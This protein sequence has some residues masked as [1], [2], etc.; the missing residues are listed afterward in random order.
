MTQ[1]DKI[2]N[3]N[4]M[5]TTNP[6]EIQ[7]IIG[8]SY[9]KLYANELDNLEEMDKFRNTH[10]LP[11][12]NQEERES[13]NRPITG[14]EI[15]SVIKNLP[16]NKSPGPDGF[17]GE[18][19]QTFKAE[20]IS[21]LFKLFQ[22]IE[23]EGK[24]PDSFYE[25]SITLMPTPDRDAVKKENYRPIFLMN[26]DA[27]IL[28]KILANRIQQHIKRI[29]HHDQ[30]GFIPGMQGWFNIRKSINVIHHIN[31]RKDKNHMI[32]SIDA[33]KAFDKIQHSF[34]F[35]FF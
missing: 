31:K 27:K 23:R 2:M 8:E 12:L 25:A 29:I 19:Y 33:E 6:S 20:I 1:I 22:E 7:A 10:T 30:L 32:L 34:F 4:G 13:L 28:N 18:F 3:E 24:L 35:F 5:I 26:I 16:T 15:E 14:E 11:T 21:I 17:P 9:E